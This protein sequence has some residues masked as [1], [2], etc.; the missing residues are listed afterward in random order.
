[1]TNEKTKYEP[2]FHVTK[3]SNIS[4]GKA[5]LIRVCG[6]LAALIICGIMSVILIK[7]NPFKIY[8]TLVTGAF[9]DVWT[10]M[11]DTAV[12]LMFGLAVI[13]AFKMRFWNMGANGQVLVGC[14]V[15]IACMKFLAGKMPNALLIVLMVVTSIAAGIIWAV[16]PAIW[17]VS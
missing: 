5:L 6:V 7:E 12:L 15:A 10:L 2:L 13:P 14:F 16:L 9:I 11:K 1:M 4:R 17:A 3:K 8:G